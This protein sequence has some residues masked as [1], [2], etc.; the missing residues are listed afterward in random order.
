MAEEL[1]AL[2]GFLLVPILILLLI[3]GVQF[4]RTGDA[5]AARAAA[6]APW[7]LALAA[8]FLVLSLIGR[9]AQNF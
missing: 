2:I 3:G 4:L 1:G 6:T 5:Q 8:L 9:F 7:A